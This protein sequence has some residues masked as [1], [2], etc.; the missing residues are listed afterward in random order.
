MIPLVLYMCVVT[1]ANLQREVGGQ[2][3][4]VFSFNLYMGSGDQNQIVL[5]GKCL[6]SVSH[7]AA[8]LL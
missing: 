3:E 8:Y 5:H 1:C 6:Y 7:P 4:L 2:A